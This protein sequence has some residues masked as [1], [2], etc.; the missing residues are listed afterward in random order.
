MFLLR[1]PDSNAFSTGQVDSIH[2]ATDRDED[3]ELDLVALLG[4]L[5]HLRDGIEAA[6][7]ACRPAQSLK[8]AEDFA[9]QLTAF[10]ERFELSTGRDLDQ[11]YAGI[12]DFRAAVPLLHEKV[13]GSGVRSLLGI[14]GRAGDAEALRPVA[15]K[16]FTALYN[17]TVAFFVTFTNRFSTS[18]AARGW[19]EVAAS[20]V[21]E[22]KNLT[23]DPLAFDS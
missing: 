8:L 20:F 21:V 22:L 17:A 2:G 13:Q 16:C 6:H 4:H 7:T 23:R 12:A 14:A 1:G 3:F 5:D 18:K 19:V 15:D 11:A 9:D 10:A